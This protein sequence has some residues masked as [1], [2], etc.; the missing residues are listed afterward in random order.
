MLSSAAC[1]AVQY[2]STLSHKRQDFRKKEN[3]LNIDCVL[4]SPKTLVWNFLI[5]IKI[6]RDTVKNVYWSSFEVPLFLVDFNVVRIFSIDFRKKNSN[7][8]FHENPS[9]GNR[10][11]QCGGTDRQSDGRT[12]RYDEANSRF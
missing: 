3:L 4:I 11:I 2:F 6:E 7:I 1:P 5:L 10:V 8:Q 12:D 9:S